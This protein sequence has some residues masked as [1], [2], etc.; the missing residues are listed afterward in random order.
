M[1][2][3]SARRERARQQ[4]AWDEGVAKALQ[5]TEWMDERNERVIGIRSVRSPEAAER[6]GIRRL[7]HT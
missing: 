5:R 4:A 1:N 2:P 3:W 6:A 7:L